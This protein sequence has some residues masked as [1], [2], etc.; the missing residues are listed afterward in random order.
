VRLPRP[1]SAGPRVLAPLA[2]AASRDGREQSGACPGDRLLTKQ[3]GGVC[4]G[5]GF[6]PRLGFEGD[7]DEIDEPPE[8]PSRMSG[9]WLYVTRDRAGRG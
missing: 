9:R 8:D 7:G 5:A 1:A 4:D 2:S 6:R 3:L